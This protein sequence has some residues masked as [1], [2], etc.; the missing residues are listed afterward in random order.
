VSSTYLIIKS[1]TA[2]TQLQSLLA[3][4]AGAYAESHGGVGS[5]RI[6]MQ[7]RRVA[8]MFRAYSQ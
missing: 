1:R 5:F 4:V 6:V 3:E 7:K 8:R 2:A